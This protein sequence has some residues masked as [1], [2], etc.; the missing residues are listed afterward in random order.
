MNRPERWLVSLLRLTALG[1][2]LAVVPLLMPY[3]WWDWVHRGM[4]LGPFPDAPVVDY[5]TRSVCAFYAMFGGLLWVVSRDVRKHAPVIRY[6]AWVGAAFSVFITAIDALLG[7]PWYWTWVEGP[8]TLAA[9][10]A[11]LVLL[12]KLPAETPGP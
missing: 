12:A 1:T 10:A 11:I 7:L 2:M 6:V 8:L 4:G 5:L 3:A 9:C